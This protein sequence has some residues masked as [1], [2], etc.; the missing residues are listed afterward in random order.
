MSGGTRSAYWVSLNERTDRRAWWTSRW[1]AG[2]HRTMTLRY[3]WPEAPSTCPPD[4]SARMTGRETDSET[5]AF[6][7]DS[8]P[9]LFGFVSKRYL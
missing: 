4:Y 2:G 6:F 1:G 3:V 8:R 5:S 7:K 9:S